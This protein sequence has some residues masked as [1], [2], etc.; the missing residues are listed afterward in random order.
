MKATHGALHHVELWVC[1]LVAAERSLGWL[2]LALGY[3]ECDRWRQGVSYRLGT[4]YI[5]LEASPAVRGDHDRMRAGLNHL[6]FHVRTASEVESLVRKA[7]GRGWALMFA[8]RHPHAAGPD[9]YVAYLENL[10]GF[11]VELVAMDMDA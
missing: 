1:D 6:A 10:A 11:E 2:L 3:Q 8:D 4:T 9:R 7:A 5:V